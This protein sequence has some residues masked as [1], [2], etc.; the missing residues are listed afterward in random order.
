MLHVRFQDHM[1]SD[2]GTDFK[3]FYHIWARPPSW[4]CGLDHLYQLSFTLP[5]E[6][7]MKFGFD[8]P[9]GYGEENV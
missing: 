2:S 1:T 8:W 9:S 4:S 7:H 5:K 3:G 6:L